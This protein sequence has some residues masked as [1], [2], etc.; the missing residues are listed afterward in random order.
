[1]VRASMLLNRSTRT[2]RRCRCAV[3]RASLGASFVG[4]M[5]T[6]SSSIARAALAQKKST[7]K[8][9]RRCCLRNFFPSWPLRRRRQ[10]RSSA[11]LAARRRWR[12]PA[13]RIGEYVGSLIRSTVNSVPPH[14]SPLPLRGERGSNSRL[15][16]SPSR[17]EGRGEGTSLPPLRGRGGPRASGRRENTHP[18]LS[19]PP[20]ATGV[21]RRGAHSSRIQ[22]TSRRCPNP[23]SAPG[24]LCCRCSASSPPGPKVLRGFFTRGALGVFPVSVLAAAG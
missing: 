12:A 5:L 2:P 14:P 6:P 22:L 8:W 13:S 21:S 17:G 7:M 24:R 4:E 15:P 20:V 16:L 1:M 11:S 10:R 19:S 18:P 9:S 3:L 23:S